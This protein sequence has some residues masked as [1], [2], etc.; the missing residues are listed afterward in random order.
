MT[1][2][3]TLLALVDNP[4]WFCLKAEPKREHLAATALRRR[5]G[6]EGLSPRLRF[7]KVT[8]RGPLWLVE[9]MFAGYLFSKFVYSTQHRAVE[10]SHGVRG[11]VQLRDAEWNRQISKT[12]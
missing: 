6:I 11:I 2:S 9:A 4:V 7:R 3:P 10:S 8:P 5:F 1:E 12:N